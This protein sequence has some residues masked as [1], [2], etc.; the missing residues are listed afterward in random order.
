MTKTK[1]HVLQITGAMNMGGAEVMMMDVTRHKSQDIHFDYLINYNTKAK[2]K[3]GDF[4]AELEERGCGLYHI[5]AQWD[6]GPYDYIKKFKQLIGIIGVPDVAHIHMNAK[7]GIIALAAKRAGIKKIIVHSHADLKIRG[8]WFKVFL[9]KIELK[10]QQYL[11]ARFAT[12][13]WGCSKEANE[14]LYYKNLLTSEH[15]AIINNAVDV[16]KFQSPNM[17]AVK[18]LQSQL[19]LKE[20]T[21]ILGN[22]GRVVRHKNV[23]FIIEVL[24]RLN[25]E[26]IDF[27][28]VYAGRDDDKKYQ[29]EILEKAKKFNVLDKVYYLGSREDVNTVIKVMDVFVGP[30]LQEGFGLVAVEAQAAGIPCVLYNGFPRSVDMGLN[31]VQFLDHFEVDSWIDAIKTSKKNPNLHE[32]HGKIAEEGF[33]VVANTRRI[34]FLY[35]Q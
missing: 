3:T 1:L 6:I 13:Y 26:G 17:D 30:A 9:S 35:N 34:E 29:Q 15:S 5:G 10:F 27:R 18:E 24:S 14:S 8:H 25:N 22:I 20:D 4:D 2:I 16:A 19:K 23:S 33:D 32:I 28:F 12:D 7:S 11:M 31:M 21:L